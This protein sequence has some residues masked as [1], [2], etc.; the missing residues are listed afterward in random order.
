[1]SRKELMR[2]IKEYDFAAYELMLFLDTHP[3]DTKALAMY[4]EV[5]KKAKLLRSEYET[6][7]GPIT[8]NN[9]MSKESWTWIDSP[10]PWEND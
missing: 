10:W 8:A 4:H 5:V 1:M 7:Y 6:N 2:Q 9:V 3:K